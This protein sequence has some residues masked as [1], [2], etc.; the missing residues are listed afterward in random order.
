MLIDALRR[1]LGDPSASSFQLMG[2]ALQRIT[3]EDLRAAVDAHEAAVPPLLREALYAEEAALGAE[4][5]EWLRKYNRSLYGRIAGYW[6]LAERLTFRYPWPIIA[7]LGIV[8]V[9][10]GMD[11]ARVYGLA[12][13]LASRLGYDKY[14]KLGD[15]SEDV[16]RRTNRGI[17]ADSI[18]TVL[19]ALR[20]EQLIAEGKR[21]LAD[22]LI[23]GHAAVLWD[24]E[25]RELCR[26][27]VE[28]LMT[29]G[30]AER[31]R[32]LSAT[33]LRHFSREQAIF[34]HQIGSKSR[35]RK[36]PAAKAVPAPVIEGGELR[37][38]SFALP[39]GFDFRDHD[40]RVD[41]FGK[42]FVTSVTGSLDDY[43][44]A[45]GWVRDRYS[46]K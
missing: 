42:A 3:V 17:F 6:A 7:I 5:H 26:A 23:T 16:L 34:T 33:T 39:P 29:A 27:I 40:T 22:A 21:E 19:R 31:F 20:A 1:R 12:G 9:I 43:R 24:E 36:L 15:G 44:V 14:E 45:I 37:Y 41:A 35:K 32:S 38:R 28:G 18:P 30:E 13:R 25:S 4:A 11:R 10:G 8:Q 46:P 2:E